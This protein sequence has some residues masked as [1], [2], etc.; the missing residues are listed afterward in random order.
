ML[1]HGENAATRKVNALRAP[2]T[3]SGLCVAGVT[4]AA[5]SG[6]LGGIATERAALGDDANKGPLII[7][8]ERKPSLAAGSGD[9]ITQTRCVLEWS[10][11]GSIQRSKN[12][13][14]SALPR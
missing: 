9:Q 1:S 5:T 4:V 2:L 11:T 8:I 3:L 7:H 10:G 14:S 12:C 13:S 6:A